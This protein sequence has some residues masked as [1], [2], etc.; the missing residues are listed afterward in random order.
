MEQTEKHCH[1][2]RWDVIN[3][4]KTFKSAQG[5]NESDAQLTLLVFSELFHIQALTWMIL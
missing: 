1:C 2:H 3:A 5:R 4:R